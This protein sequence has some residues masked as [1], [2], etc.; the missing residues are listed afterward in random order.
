M[1]KIVHSK[2]AK[3]REGRAVTGQPFK[4]CMPQRIIRQI[5]GLQ[6]LAT[7]P[8]LE[9]IRQARD[10]NFVHG[11]IQLTN[12]AKRR[13]FERTLRPASPSLAYGNSR[14]VIQ[15]K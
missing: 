2:P 7:D 11:Q 1:A 10:G 9:E 14:R 4:P 15:G 6:A 13:A 12:I 8:I 5:K 3:T